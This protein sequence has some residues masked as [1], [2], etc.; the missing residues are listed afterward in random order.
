MVADVLRDARYGVRQLTQ[1]PGVRGGGHRSRSRSA[2][3]PPAR[4]SASSMACCC[5]RCRSRSRTRWCASTRSCRTTAASRS[6]RRPSSTGARRARRSSGSSRRR[7]A[8]ATLRRRNGAERITNALGVVGLLRAGA[9]LPGARPGVHG[10]RGR[11]GKNNVVVL[12]HGMWQR[13]SAADPDIVGRSI[14]AQRHAG[15][16]HRRDARRLRVPARTPS[17]GRRSRS[18]RPTPTRGGAFPR[19]RRAVEAR[20][21]RGAGRRRDE[22]DF[23]AAGDSSI[24]KRAP[25]S[26]RRSCRSSI[27]SSAASRQSLLALLAAVGVVVLIACANVANLL[28]VRASVR[29]KEIAIRTALGA[30]QGAAGQADARREPRAR[31]GRRRRSACSSPTWR[32]ARFRR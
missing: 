14:D 7:A 30:G 1:E 32:S 17:I 9:R 31:A 13:G 19:R 11:P 22:D 26:R 3:A 20:R 8:T 24:R 23:R 12:S 2:S 18:T 27:R 28:L 5:G 4:C 15:D 10:G 16:D 21:H 25:T 29:E 6:R